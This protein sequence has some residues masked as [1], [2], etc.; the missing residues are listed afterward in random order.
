M[1]Y[2]A[3]EA[4]LLVKYL[5]INAFIVVQFCLI[6]IFSALIGAAFL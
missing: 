5:K 3:S 4:W 6:L 2:R 1:S